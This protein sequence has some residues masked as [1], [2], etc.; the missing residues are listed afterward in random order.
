MERA[1]VS[2]LQRPGLVAAGR[3]NEFL[4]MLASHDTIVMW[5][6]SNTL[7]K[8]RA[9]INENLAALEAQGLLKRAHGGSLPVTTA[10]IIDQA[11]R[12]PLMIDHSELNRDALVAYSSPQKVDLLIADSEAP[13][14]TWSEPEKEG[15]GAFAA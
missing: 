8:S 7:R 13:Q 2:E 6:A 15:V 3:R 14:I 12:I 11:T 9:T 5:W 4:A 10:R 1:A